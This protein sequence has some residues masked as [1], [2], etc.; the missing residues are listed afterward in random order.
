LDFQ[1][2]NVT[3]PFR[4]KKRTL[5]QTTSKWSEIWYLAWIHTNKL[6]YQVWFNS[7]LIWYMDVKLA[8]ISLFKTW[9]W[10]LNQ[11]MSKWVE[12]WYVV[13]FTLNNWNIN[14]ETITIWFDN[15]TQ[16]EAKQTPFSFSFLFMFFYS[17]K[18]I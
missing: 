3:N 9:I 12:N 4:P 8:R 10:N 6:E 13:R 2:T 14:F 18:K 16:K 11:T 17:K 7:E 15:R 1:L 5:N